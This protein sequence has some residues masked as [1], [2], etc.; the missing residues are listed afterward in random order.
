MPITMSGREVSLVSR[1]DFTAL[2]S[3]PA[4]TAAT[5]PGLRFEFRTGRWQDLFIAPQT[6]PVSATG[7]VDDLFQTPEQKPHAIYSIR[8]SGYL[9]APADGVYTFH[10]PPESYQMNF[11]A[12]YEMQLF[13]DGHQWDPATT[14]HA[15]GAWSIALKQGN[16]HFEVLYADLRGDAPERTNPVGYAPWIWTGQ[17][18]VL[19]LEGPGIPLG[20]ISKSLL[21]CDPAAPTTAMAP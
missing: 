9:N 4:V 19:Q 16:H 6:V 15:L 13:V 14:R 1:A 7:R 21:S 10:A 2:T 8:Y 12:G 5:I 18:P 3:L 17:R 20:P 11:V